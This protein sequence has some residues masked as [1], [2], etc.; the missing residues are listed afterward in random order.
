MT[1]IQQ[2]YN[3]IHEIPQLFLD[4]YIAGVPVELNPVLRNEQSRSP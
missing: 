2:N 4:I 1:H 3:I